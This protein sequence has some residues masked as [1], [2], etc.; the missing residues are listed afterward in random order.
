MTVAIQSKS[1]MDK[2]NEF[3]KHPYFRGLIEK[4]LLPMIEAKK[5]ADAANQEFILSPSQQYHVDVFFYSASMYE[6]VK[7]LYDIP[8]FIVSNPS[9]KGMANHGVTAQEWFVY[10]YANYRVIA[11]GIYDT[12]LI[13]TNF[14]LKI[15]RLSR[16]CN[17]KS[18]LQHPQTKE[19]G[20][21]I[22]LLGF[23]NVIEKYREERHHYVHRSERPDLEF[24]D[25]LNGYRFL[26]EAKEI[27]LYKG[28]LPNQ[29]VANAHFMSERNKKREEMKAETDEI[30][31]A[32]LE[33]LDVWHPVYLEMLEV[34]DAKN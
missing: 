18:I 33:L 4:S 13:V 23:S 5:E 12:A 15:G 16:N 34:L 14:L 20:V 19:K 24:V 10:H 2:F 22:P 26:K 17:N 30:C 31:L 7:R 29:Q 27:G 32:L 11:T 3:V 25:Q 21:Y 9:F 6:A 1:A 8:F 28:H